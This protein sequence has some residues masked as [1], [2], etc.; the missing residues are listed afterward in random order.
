MK[1]EKRVVQKVDLMVET[2]VKTLA[3]LSVVV[4]AEMLDRLR[5]VPL[6]VCWAQMTV[7]LLVART[8]VPLADS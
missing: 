7:E 2:M 4:M 6:V 5:V 8:V 3:D 1:V